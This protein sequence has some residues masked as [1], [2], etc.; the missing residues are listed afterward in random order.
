[1]AP[2]VDHPSATVQSANFGQTPARERQAVIGPPGQRE[3][4][5]LLP[6]RQAELRWPS[7]AILQQSR[8][9]SWLPGGSAMAENDRWCC[10]PT[11]AFPWH[12]RPLLSPAPGPCH[13]GLHAAAT[14]TQVSFSDSHRIPNN[15]SP[16]YI[17]DTA[18]GTQRGGATSMAIDHRPGRCRLRSAGLCKVPGDGSDSVR[19]VIGEIGLD[20]S[21]FGTDTSD[22][23]RGRKQRP[24][25]SSSATKRQTST[26]KGNPYLKAAL[27]QLVTGAARP[28]AFSANATGD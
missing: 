26:G 12:S 3:V 7:A 2:V 13:E 24:A 17:W 19:A 11:P 28:T 21:V 16:T 27:G 9:S 23:A 8:L 1:M 20:M 15:P 25:P 14:S 22:C 6:L 10:P 5:D 4:P 18:S